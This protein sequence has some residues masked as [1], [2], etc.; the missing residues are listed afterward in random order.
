MGKFDALPPVDKKDAVDT[1]AKDKPPRA[2]FLKGN[3]IATAAAGRGNGGIF[4]G[5]DKHKAILGLIIGIAFVA[6]F[7]AMGIGLAAQCVVSRTKQNRTSLFSNIRTPNE[8]DRTPPELRGNGAPTFVQPKPHELDP[9]VK[10]HR[11][12]GS[13]HGQVS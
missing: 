4:V 1:N 12:S 10:G 7:V 6:V 9:G 13:R 11:G 5:E 3:Y 2:G 8:E